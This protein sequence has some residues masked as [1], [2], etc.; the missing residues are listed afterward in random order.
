MNRFLAQ[1]IIDDGGRL[2]PLA[3]LTL[4]GD[5][6]HSIEPFVE[7]TAATAYVDG[8]LVIGS[9]LPDGFRR[10]RRC[11]DKP[12]VWICKKANTENL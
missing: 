5:G 8:V 6:S 4:P 10:V 12:E 3:V 11:S 2:H 9:A 1:T 7:E